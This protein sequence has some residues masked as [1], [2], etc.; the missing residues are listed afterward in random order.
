ML[1]QILRGCAR[2]GIDADSWNFVMYRND[3]P[4][5]WNFVM[6]WNDVPQ[7]IGIETDSW[8]FA[9]YRNDVPEMELKQIVEIL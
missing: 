8:H 7:I 2:D 6:Y 3:V 4:D 9:M 1:L 5:N